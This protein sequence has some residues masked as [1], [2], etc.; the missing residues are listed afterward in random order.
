MA[1]EERWQLR[2]RTLTAILVHSS[3]IAQT[4]LPARQRR[5]NRSALG[6]LPANSCADISCRTLPTC[7]WRALAFSARRRQLTVHRV[8]D[9][10]LEAFLRL[11]NPPARPSFDDDLESLDSDQVDELLAS[12]AD[13]YER[14]KAIVPPETPPAT[15][16][17]VNVTPVMQSKPFNAASFLPPTPPDTPQTLPEAVSPD[18]AGPRLGLALQRAGEAAHGRTDS[19]EQAALPSVQE[20]SLALGLGSPLMRPQPSIDALKATRQRS[21]SSLRSLCQ[22]PPLPPSASSTS[23]FPSREHKRSLSSMRN[24][25]APLPSSQHKKQQD[26]L[27]DLVAAIDD[28]LTP[29]HSPAPSTTSRRS[30]AQQQRQRAASS[31]LH[32][33][34]TD[35]ENE[36]MRE[37]TAEEGGEELRRFLTNTPNVD[38]PV[39]EER[40]PTPTLNDPSGFAAAAAAER[41]RKR[42]EARGPPVTFAS[43]PASRARSTTPTLPKKVRSDLS[44]LR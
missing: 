13:D 42:S 3:Y 39:R 37:V 40:P 30:L 33:I 31:A 18:R 14:P 27:A 6:P 41:E 7:N 20:K 25:S 35:R 43:R 8:D 22:L 5:Q 32:N 1:A 23:S 10:K 17:V 19:M 36:V 4:A 34:V 11:N 38:G 12:Y 21:Q 9:G 26:S 29:E 44:A 16:K 28:I 24:V 15:P 2:V